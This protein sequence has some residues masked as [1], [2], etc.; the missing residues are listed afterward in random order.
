MNKYRAWAAAR[1]HEVANAERMFPSRPN[2]AALWPGPAELAIGA[3]LNAL[4]KAR[5]SVENC[6]Q[7]SI[8]QEKN[9]CWD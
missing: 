9:R 3:A 6:P 1:L 5:R 8:K 4:D 7:P 2:A